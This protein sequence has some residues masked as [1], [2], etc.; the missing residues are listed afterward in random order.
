MRERLATLHSRV[1]LGITVIGL[2][3]F[4][5]FLLQ[6]TDAIPVRLLFWDADIPSVIVILVT[7]LGGFAVGYYVAFT[8]QRR[9]S[10]RRADKQR[11]K[12]SETHADNAQ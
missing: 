4:I 5:V 10:K 3:V 8:G 1:R 7:S 11:A 2:L 6:N 12:A 9:R